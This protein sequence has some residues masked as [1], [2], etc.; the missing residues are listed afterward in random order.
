M[1]NSSIYAK[2]TVEFATVAAEYCA[3]IENA[4]NSEKN[5]FIDKC[6]KLLPLLYLK[7]VLLPISEYELEEESERFVS[8]EM[9]EYIRCSIAPILGSNDDYLEVFCEDM[10]YS[11]TPIT[12]NISEDLAD[13]YQD[14]KDFISVYSQGFEPT[15]NDALTLLNDNFRQYWGQKLLNAM[16]PLHTLRFIDTDEEEDNE[17]SMYDTNR[18]THRVFDAQKTDDETLNMDDEWYS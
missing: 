12:A 2:Q 7:A 5:Q 10:K 13:I 11:E 4:P 1:S 17:R 16:R 3:F 8:E 14:L 15:M 9:Y 18:S 6:L